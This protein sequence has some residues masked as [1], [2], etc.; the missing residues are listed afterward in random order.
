MAKDVNSD[1]LISH[2]CSVD[3]NTG[4]EIDA[5]NGK[6]RLSRLPKAPEGM[7]IDQVEVIIHTTRRNVPKGS[8]GG[9]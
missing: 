5:S 3:K 2:R 8:D 9:S 1:T 7:E 6:V 4:K